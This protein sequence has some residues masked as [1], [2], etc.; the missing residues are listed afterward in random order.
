MAFEDRFLQ[1]RLFGLF[2]FGW[3]KSHRQAAIAVSH[4][5]RSHLLH[6]KLYRKQMCTIRPNIQ[7]WSTLN[8]FNVLLTI[9]NPFLTDD[10]VSVLKNVSIYSKPIFGWLLYDVSGKMY[11]LQVPS[12]ICQTYAWKE[13]GTKVILSQGGRSKMFNLTFMN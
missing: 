5:C 10:I 13:L 4:C 6:I 7:Q 3:T 12:R 2:A 11:A 9:P 8:Y 1:L